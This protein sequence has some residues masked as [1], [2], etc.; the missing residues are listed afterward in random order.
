MQ[1]KLVRDGIE[2]YYSD[3]NVVDIDPVILRIIAEDLSCE[4]SDIK[5]YYHPC[6]Q[7]EVLTVGGKYMGY[8]EQYET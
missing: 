6:I 2:D 7:Q 5:C 3:N 8:L 1:D 4:I